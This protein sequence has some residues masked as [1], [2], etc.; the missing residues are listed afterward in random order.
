MRWLL[1]LCTLGWLTGCAG[2]TLAPHALDRAVHVQ[3]V[4]LDFAPTGE[5]SLRLRLQVANPTLADAVATGVDYELAVEGRSYAAGT[6]RVRLELPA[7]AQHSLEVAFPLLAVPA[8]PQA[9][10]RAVHV[11]LRGSVALLFQD[12]ERRLP[13]RSEQVLRVAHLKP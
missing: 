2:V 12:M 4:A 7:G 5:G 1:A 13:F 9:P 11:A 3:E 6:R 8:A 10:E